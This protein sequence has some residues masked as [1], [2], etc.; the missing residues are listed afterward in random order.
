[1]KG[2]ADTAG[3]PSRRTASRLPFLVPFG[4]TPR[5]PPRSG[6]SGR[7]VGLVHQGGAER[8]VVI[9]GQLCLQ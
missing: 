6:Y 3:M 7:V 9:G 8:G 5:F 4:G 2:R 1:M